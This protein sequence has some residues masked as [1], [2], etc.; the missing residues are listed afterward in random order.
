MMGWLEMMVVVV[1]SKY[2]YIQSH[3]IAYF[4]SYGVYI[5]CIMFSI[6]NFW[7]VVEWDKCLS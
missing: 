3:D 1:T 4:N 6:F 2:H 5:I 7:S